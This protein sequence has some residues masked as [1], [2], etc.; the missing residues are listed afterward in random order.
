[1]QDDL[2]RAGI[3]SY[4]WVINASLTA[5]GTRD[6]LLRARAALEHRQL[7]RV[8]DGLAARAWLV[9]W[10]VDALAGEDRLAALTGR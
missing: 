10:Q 6:P 2:R 4:G 1:L 8:R 7:T 9:P 5:S 3:E